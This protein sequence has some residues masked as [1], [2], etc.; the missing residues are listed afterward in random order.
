VE[1]AAQERRDQIAVRLSAAQDSLEHAN[2]GRK[3][4]TA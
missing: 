3:V 2:A 1:G 4:L